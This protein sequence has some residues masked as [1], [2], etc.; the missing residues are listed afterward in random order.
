MVPL[1]PGGALLVTPDLYQSRLARA[2]RVG[3]FIPAIVASEGMALVFVS[4]SL[5]W[6]ARCKLHPGGALDA[7]RLEQGRG[8]R[9]APSPWFIKHVT[10][11]LL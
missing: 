5:A 7:N 10:P 8:M 1:D 6:R 3:L 11:S 9:L 4:P 2:H